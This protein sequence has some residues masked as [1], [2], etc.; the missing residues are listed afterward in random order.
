MTNDQK[1]NHRPFP[2]N[3]MKTHIHPLGALTFVIRH[4]TFLLGLLL[5]LP[6]WAV[7]QTVTSAVPGTISYQGRV[8]NSSGGLV[9]GAGTPVNRTVIF[10]IWD[11]PSNTLAGNLLYSEQ[12]TVTIAEGEFSVLV[13]QGTGTSIE[14]FGYSETN[15]GPSG[16]P[17]VSLP[18]VFNGAT[19]YLGVTVAAG[20]SIQPTDNEITPRQQIVGSAFAFRARFAESIG[21]NGVSAI[22][23]VDGGNVGVGTSAPP[24]LFTIAGSNNSPT[25]NTPQLVITDPADLNERLLI[26]MDRTGNGSG[27]IQATKVG[28]G[29]QNLLLNPSGGFVGIGSTTAPTAALDVAGGIKAT[30]AGGHTFNTGDLDG[31]LFSPADGVVTL[32]TNGTERLR[33]NASG[34][35]GI[36]TTIINHRLQ[37]SGNVMLGTGAPD[38]TF[39]S[40]GDTLYLGQPRKFLST[41]LATAVGGSTDWLNLMCHNGSAGILFGGATSD[42]TPHSNPDVYMTIKPSGNVGIGT[43]SPVYKLQVNGGN[44]VASG[45]AASDSFGFVGVTNTGVERF[46]IGFAGGSGSWSTDAATGDAI[47][48]GSNGKLLLQSGSGASAICINTSN[49]V[50]IGTTSPQRNLQIGSFTGGDKY[51][52]LAS[53]GGNIARSGL[54]LFHFNSSTG[55]SIVSDERSAGPQGLHFINHGGAGGTRMFIDYYNGRVGVGTTAPQCP[56]DVRGGTDV[57]LNGNYTSIKSEWYVQA[58]GYGTMSDQRIKQI[59]DRSNSASDLDTVMKLQVTDYQMKAQVMK[60]NPVH[61]GLIAQEVEKVIPEAVL[62]SE[63]YV[64]EIFELAQQAEYD[65]D[66]RSLKVTMGKPHEL[67]V[68]DMVMITSKDTKTDQSHYLKVTQVTDAKAFVVGDVVAEIKKV[69]VFGKQVKDFRSVDYNRVYTTGIGAIQ[70]L[71]KEKDAEV[72]SLKEENEALKTRIKAMEASAKE[73]EEADKAIVTKLAALEKL[74]KDNAKAAAQPVSLKR[75]AGGAE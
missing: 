22:T 32:R 64:P 46:S 54:E 67:A 38:A 30:G 25:T 62:K 21:S 39:T 40:I 49:N 9:G 41:S 59:I 36:G 34:N 1:F 17:A 28:N 14:T 7:A 37:V 52:R 3:I 6:T 73:R 24:A 68:G 10:R 2:E 11:H 23:A 31:G 71:K 63:A 65:S 33:V 44:V 4:S 51:I 56:L 66:S 50:G 18:N 72:K 47:V 13:G 60:G 16:A 19:R 35:L 48:R 58:F 69:F 45:A 15:K 74:I 26:G 61:K 70:Q 8:L 5:L 57:V 53:Q 27:I 55:F 20:A 29:P 42:A 12:Q 75:S 43:T